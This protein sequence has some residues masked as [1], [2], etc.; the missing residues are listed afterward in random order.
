MI[1][2]LLGIPLLQVSIFLDLASFYLIGGLLLLSNKLSLKENN[3]RTKF[4]VLLCIF[5][6][7]DSLLS[8]IWYGSMFITGRTVSFLA[9]VDTF[10]SELS[11]I[12]FCAGWS[13]YVLYMLYESKDMVTRGFKK[14]IRPAT[15]CLVV[16]VLINGVA[17]HYTESSPKL[18]GV[19]TVTSSLIHLIELGFFIGSGVVIYRYRRSHLNSPT[20]RVMPFIVPMVLTMGLTEYMSFSVMSF[21]CSVALIDLYFSMIEIWK[22]KDSDQSYYKSEYV[23]EIVKEAE[24]GK[25]TLGSALYIDVSGNADELPNIVNA[26]LPHGM[27]LV[28]INKDD[29]VVFVESRKQTFLKSLCDIIE[30]V[31][32]EYDEEHPDDLINVEI[33]VLRINDDEPP[34]DFVGRMMK[35]AE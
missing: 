17:S 13:A 22:Y 7:L 6:L 24:S 10:A 15:G 26:E 14:A 9:T 30:D 16:L 1:A 3:P 4:F 21:G 32:L 11:F 18:L 29:F 20:I 31:I 35:A 33:S 2:K 8:I 5:N 19:V 28:R 27:E 23:E 25:R 12:G 34:G